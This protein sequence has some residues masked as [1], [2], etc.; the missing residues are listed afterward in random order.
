MKLGGFYSTKI[1]YGLKGMNNH[2]TQ[3]VV[4]PLH[5]VSTNKTTLEPI[6]TW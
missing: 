5:T 4:F 2:Y 6:H 3:Y 1:L